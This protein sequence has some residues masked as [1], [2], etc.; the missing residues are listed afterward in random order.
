MKNPQYP[1]PGCIRK[2]CTQQKY[3]RWLRAKASAHARRDRKR[4]R[5]GWTVARYKAGIHEAV[6]AGGGRDY[7]TGE[8][9]EWQRVSTFQNAAAQEGKVKYKKSF[10][11]L[12]TVDHTFDERGQ[13]KLVICS[14]RVNDAKSDL[15]ETEF[16]ELCARVLQHRVGRVGRREAPAK[17]RIARGK[18]D[19]L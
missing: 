3:S 10:A 8:P 9:L 2:K 14:W 13:Q 6:V 18:T 17:R 19:S 12:P 7:Y 11:L 4:N 1:V 16:R 5:S 15:T